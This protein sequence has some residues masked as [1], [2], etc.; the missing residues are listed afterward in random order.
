MSLQMFDERSTLR[1]AEQSIA[2]ARERVILQRRRIAD[3]QRSGYSA[4]GCISLL[5]ELETTLR[6]M[7]VRRDV[8]ARRLKRR[9]EPRAASASLVKH[10]TRSH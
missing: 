3:L 2:D 9:H 1:D 10:L 4:V 7:N 5:R 6:L 8:I